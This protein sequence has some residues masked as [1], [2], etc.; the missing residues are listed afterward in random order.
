M[1]GEWSWGPSSSRSSSTLI[2]Q[3]AR[4]SGM[5]T[6]AKLA[7]EGLV[8][9]GP[10]LR[11]GLRCGRGGLVSGYLRQSFLGSHGTLR[12]AER[13][14]VPLAGGCQ[15][16]H[17]P[18]CLILFARG[19]LQ[20]GNFARVLSRPHLGSQFAGQAVCCLLSK[21]L[22]YGGPEAKQSA[23]NAGDPGLISRSGRFPWRR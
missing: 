12:A 17:A 19:R 8:K 5:A 14:A 13:T 16:Q 20:L 10:C 22:P 9:P 18:T 7:A 6:V 11:G 1:L 15:G 4:E 3:G 2:E 23:C 21:G